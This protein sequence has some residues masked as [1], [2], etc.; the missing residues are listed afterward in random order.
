MENKNYLLHF[1]ATVFLCCFINIDLYGQSDDCSSAPTIIVSTTGCVSVPST[2]VGSTSGNAASGGNPSCA[3][4]GGFDPTTLEDVWYRFEAV[5]SNIT[6]ETQIGS[7]GDTGIELYTS[8]DGTCNTLTSVECD[9]DGGAGTLSL[10][11]RTDLVNGQIYY[12]RMWGFNGGTGDFGICVHSVLPPANDECTGAFDLDVGQFECVFGEITNVGATY[13]NT[14]GGDP[15]C[16]NGTGAEDVWYRFVAPAGG[17]AVI[18]TEAG[19][20]T[21]SGMELYHAPDGTCGSLVSIDCDNNGGTGNMSRILEYNLIGGNTYYL[22]VWE[23]NGGTGTMDICIQNQYS[24]C[25]VSF[26]LCSSSSF[27]TNSFG[28]G[29]VD[30]N[31]GN[32]FTGGFDETELQSIWLNFEIQTSG[33]LGFVI[34]SQNPGGDDYDFN[35]FRANTCAG[36]V[37]GNSVSCNASSSTG[38]GGTTGLDTGLAGGFGDNDPDPNSENPGGGNPFN[39]DLNVVAGERYYIV[40]NN[41]SATGIGFDIAFSGTAG[42]DCVVLPLELTEFD[43][44]K[45]KD[46]NLLHWATAREFNTSHFEIE[47]SN[48]AMDFVKIGDLKCGNKKMENQIYQ[49]WDDEPQNGINYYRLKQVDLDGTFTYT[50]TI[51]IDNQG[52]IT[53]FEIQKIYPNPAQNTVNFVFAIPSSNSDIQL[54]IFDSNGKSVAKNTEN[55][56]K[57]IQN[58]NQNLS[59]FSKGLYILRISNLKTGQVLTEKFVKK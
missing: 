49:Y 36:I 41:F 50:K 30:S 5:A 26:P 47:R 54:E 35:L 12:I 22:R 43:G 32:C 16:A 31:I 56:E 2:N 21:N 42:L 19:S 29:A 9:D 53:K 1:L 55:Y 28:P 13:S 57:G 33:T 6:I 40:I 39:D 17:Q 37:G 52:V 58:F 7:L 34:D 3:F 15:S 45:V 51:A 10:I 4:G 25:D 59:S 11:T 18:D 38:A 24:D 20:I 14:F 44:E 27:N 48:D 23:N 46:Q 8:T